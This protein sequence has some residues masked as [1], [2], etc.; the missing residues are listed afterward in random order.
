[1]QAM[2]KCY[3]VPVLTIMTMGLSA[4]VSPTVSDLPSNQQVI[5]FL[6]NSIDWYRHCATERQIASNPVDLM[7]LEE[8]RPSATQVLQ[9]SFDFARSF[10]QFSARPD[11]NKESTP[12]VTGSPDLARF[13]Q[14]EKTT[15]LQIRQASEEI[16]SINT[17]IRT[18]HGDHRRQLQAALDAA[19]SRLEVLQ[20][21]LVT[22]RQLV[23]FMEAFTTREAGDL[24]STIED[25]ARTVPEITIPTS[26]SSQTQASA[27]ALSARLGDSGILALSSQVSAM[28]RKLRILDDE[29][30]RTDA[31]RQSSEE[32]RKPVLAAI[33]KLLPA[34]S[35]NVLQASNLAELQ[36]DKTKLDELA[37]LVK[38]LSP[39][40]VALDKERVLLAAN[41]A[42]LKSWRAAV[43]AEDKIIWRNLLS[44]LLGAAALIVA[45]VLT[46]AVVRRM[47]RNYMRDTERRHVILVVQRV[48][49]WSTIVAVAAFAFASDL[50]S[51][52]TFF[53]L[54]AAGLAVALQNLILSAVCYFVLV[55]RRGIR[56]GDRVQLSGVTGDVIDIDW[57]QFQLKEID[58][59]TQQPTGNVVTFSNALILASPATGL[60]KFKPNN[61]KP[62]QLEVTASALQS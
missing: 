43:I 61:L 16:E 26:A 29:I 22:L 14:L 3:C 28:G 56:I 59:R 52:A 5:A 48:I 51:L 30:R 20:A 15:E 41:T 25:L 23:D 7:F 45:L 12:T 36:R 17:R 49:V 24:A 11:T 4:Q 8:N 6:T 38:T 50:T 54:L 10:A 42:H 40:I 37:A 55:G 44:R 27:P 1:M 60:S 58:P 31:L 21:G 46:G 34:V 32:L 18:T 39:A 33:N 62:A 13:M 57:L 35:G 53:G 9:L 19:Q 47:T 2:R